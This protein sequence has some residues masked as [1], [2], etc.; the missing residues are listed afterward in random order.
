MVATSRGPT[1]LSTVT[2]YVCNDVQWKG[3]GGRGCPWNP[4]AIIMVK[5]V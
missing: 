3:G 2:R 1:M 4:A 5:R